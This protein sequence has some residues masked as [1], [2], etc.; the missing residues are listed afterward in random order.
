MILG[1]DAGTVHFSFMD[2]FDLDVDLVHHSAESTLH[3]TAAARVR[4][5]GH[6]QR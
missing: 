6:T 4:T 3:H 2:H 5:S 1:H